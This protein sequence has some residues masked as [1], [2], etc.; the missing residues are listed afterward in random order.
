MIIQLSTAMPLENVS[1]LPVGKIAPKK[2]KTKTNYS[3][4]WVNKINRSTC[5]SKKMKRKN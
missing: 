1:G 5:K 3:S 4:S 2:N